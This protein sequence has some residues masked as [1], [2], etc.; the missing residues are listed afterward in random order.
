MNPRLSKAF[1]PA[2]VDS[3]NAALKYVLQVTWKAYCDKE[4][5]EA[6]PW[7]LDAPLF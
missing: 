1:N 4:S 6:C 5:G 3:D 7:D 2:S